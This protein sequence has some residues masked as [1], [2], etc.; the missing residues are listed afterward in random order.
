[1][2]NTLRIPGSGRVVWFVVEDWLC[3]SRLRRGIICGDSKALG[4]FGVYGI[5][6]L[7]GKFWHVL[8]DRVAST[9]AELMQL[10]ARHG[11]SLSVEEEQEALSGIQDGGE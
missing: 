1:M 10:I 9:P 4:D 8:Y 6:T 11:K 5:R 7:E 3:G 2:S